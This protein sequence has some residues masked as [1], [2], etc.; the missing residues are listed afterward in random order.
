MLWEISYLVPEGFLL[1]HVYLE[2]PVNGI[3]FAFFFFFFYFPLNVCCFIFTPAG[4]GSHEHPG[5]VLTHRVQN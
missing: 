5:A 2:I 1:I 3:G 4:L